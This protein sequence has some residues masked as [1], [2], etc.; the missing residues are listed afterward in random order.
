MQLVNKYAVVLGTNN[1]ER[2]LELSTLVTRRPGVARM[3]RNEVV[4]VVQ[5]E[6]VSSAAERVS[7]VDELW[8]NGPVVDTL[9]ALRRL[10]ADSPVVQISRVAANTIFERATDGA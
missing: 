3:T 8:C 6:H 5:R 4:E 2:L 1:R 10:Y 7:C 9:T